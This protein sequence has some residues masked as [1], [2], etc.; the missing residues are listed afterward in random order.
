MRKKLG[1]NNHVDVDDDDD[2]ECSFL[3][4]SNTPDRDIAPAMPSSSP[5]SSWFNYDS[6]FD[7]PPIPY[8]LAEQRRIR[9]EKCSEEP[10]DMDMDGKISRSSSRP[11]FTGLQGVERNEVVVVVT[12]RESMAAFFPD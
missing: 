3:S 11:S 5:Y 4:S 6:I 12:V 8:H 9:S 10:G 7:P 1:S 2:D